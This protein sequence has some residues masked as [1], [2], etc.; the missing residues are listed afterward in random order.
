MSRIRLG[1]GI[2]LCCLLSAFL[3]P[4]D[5]KLLGYWSFDAKNELGKDASPNSND[6]A[7]KSGAKWMEKGKV[8]GVLLLVKQED[9]Y[10]EIPHDN[11]LNLKNQMTFRYCPG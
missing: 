2:L 3:I 7:P 5:A 11:S 9:S 6:G 10:L 1:F 4:A 8:G